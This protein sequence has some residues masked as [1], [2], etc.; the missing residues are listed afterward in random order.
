M[1]QFEAIKRKQLLETGRDLCHLHGP[2]LLS[3][4]QVAA[5]AHVS[6]RTLYKY[7]RD[8]QHFIAA[9]LDHDAE[10]WREWFFNAVS[11]RKAHPGAVLLSFYD[12]LSLW[13]SSDEFHGVLFARAALVYS[14]KMP[15]CI[16]RVVARHTGLLRDFLADAA[17]AANVI[18]SEQGVDK[19]LYLV[20]VILSGWF[21]SMAGDKAQRDGE[22]RQAALA[23]VRDAIDCL[24]QPQ[25]TRKNTQK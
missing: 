4:E 16:A 11:E 19:L 5:E 13:V 22:M 10:Q 3:A 12:V 20:L 6:K 7:F 21:A 1:T 2:L 17:H 14:N 9:I 18:K 24:Q 23:L 15:A 8:R 25:T